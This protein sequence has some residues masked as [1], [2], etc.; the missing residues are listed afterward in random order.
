MSERKITTTVKYEQNCHYNQSTQRQTAIVS[1]TTPNLIVSCSK[2]QLYYNETLTITASASIVQQNEN[3]PIMWGSVSFYFIDQN[4]ISQTKQLINANPILLNNEGTASIQYIPHN[5]G[6][7]VAEYH[8]EPY[9]ADTT[10][11]EKYLALQPRPVHIEF[12]N[13]PPYLI[14][15]YILNIG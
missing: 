5:D 4:D 3:V 7:I 9:Y 14:C 8:G 1:L 13:Y 6:S 15:S 12:D 2:D 10:S 11:K